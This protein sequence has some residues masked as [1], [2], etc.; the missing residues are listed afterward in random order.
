MDGPVDLEHEP[1]L[2]AIEVYD[3]SSD[4]VLAAEFQAEHTPIAEQLPCSPFCD[5]QVPPQFPCAPELR[6]RDRWTSEFHHPT[7]DRDLVG[8]ASDSPRESDSRIDTFPS[9]PLS[10]QRRG[11]QGVRSRAGP[12]DP[13][14][15]PRDFAPSRAFFPTAVAS[16]R[17]TVLPC[18]PGSAPP[19]CSASTPTWWT[20]RP[21]SRTASPPSRRWDCR[22]AL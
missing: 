14:L 9:F 22:R 18:S 19:R 1:Q 8:N 17:R 4:H 13:R 6:L 7:I 5:G 15:V 11:G 2:G 21:T 12:G 10:A 20:S 16:S 3:E